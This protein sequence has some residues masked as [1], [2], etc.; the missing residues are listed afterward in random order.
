MKNAFAGKW[1]K[2]IMKLESDFDSQFK[3]ENAFAGNW[4][5]TLE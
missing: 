3:T 5:K 4:S 2:T 1:N